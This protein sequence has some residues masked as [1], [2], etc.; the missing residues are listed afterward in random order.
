MEQ[1]NLFAKIMKMTW[2]KNNVLIV[3]KKKKFLLIS[4]KSQNTK[5][6]CATT[7]LNGTCKK[8]SSANHKD[9]TI[10]HRGFLYTKL[11][12]T[13]ICKTKSIHVSVAANM[14]IHLLTSKAN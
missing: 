8:L 10:A 4:L 1:K 9:A 6:F 12:I 7:V 13:L 2:S 3:K 5:D 11:L 14:L